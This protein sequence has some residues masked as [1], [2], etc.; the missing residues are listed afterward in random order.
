MFSSIC[1]AGIARVWRW[2]FLLPFE[3]VQHLLQ[4]LCLLREFQPDFQILHFLLQGLLLRI[5]RFHG[6][7]AIAIRQCCQHSLQA[8]MLPFVVRIPRYSQSIR[9]F[10]RF[11]VPCLH[12]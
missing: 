10:G 4:H 5:A 3:V 1:V 9:S 6:T 8:A 2:R 11:Q 12:F 7:T